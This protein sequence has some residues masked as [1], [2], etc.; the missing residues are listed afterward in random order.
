M[1]TVKSGLTYYE[2]SKKVTLVGTKYGIAYNG[3]FDSCS[4]LSQVILNGSTS[5]TS[6]S[7]SNCSSSLKIINSNGIISDIAKYVPADN[8]GPLESPPTVIQ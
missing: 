5:L 2:S 4:S 3:V 6:Q 1:V 8:K 7:F